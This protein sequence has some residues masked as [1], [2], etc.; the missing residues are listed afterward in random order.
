MNVAGLS[1][2]VMGDIPVVCDM[3]VRYLTGVYG[4]P[5]RYPTVMSDTA[6]RYP[7]VASRS[8]ADP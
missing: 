8:T 2:V 7:A 5:V 1:S 4:M 6:T 3:T